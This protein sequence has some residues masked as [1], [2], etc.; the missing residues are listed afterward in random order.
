MAMERANGSSNCKNYGNQNLHC[1]IGIY[2][3]SFDTCILLFDKDLMMLL[4]KVVGQCVSSSSQIIDPFVG[5]EGS[6]GHVEARHLIGVQSEIS[7]KHQKLPFRSFG[8]EY[9]G[10][11]LSFAITSLSEKELF[12]LDP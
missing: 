11:K 10:D 7:E 1:E 3:S 9:K 12:F 8:R 5:A 2:C 4:Y 6:V